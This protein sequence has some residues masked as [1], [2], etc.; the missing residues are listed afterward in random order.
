MIGCLCS[1]FPSTFDFILFPT[2]AVG[3]SVFDKVIFRAIDSFAK[4]YLMQ[5]GSHK[6]GNLGKTE[7]LVAGGS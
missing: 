7:L 1:N 4:S 3:Q 2:L 5:A 6:L